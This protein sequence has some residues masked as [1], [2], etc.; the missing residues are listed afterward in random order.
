MTRYVDIFGMMYYI[1]IPLT[2]RDK[3]NIITKEQNH[4]IPDVKWELIQRILLTEQKFGHNITPLDLLRNFEVQEI[5]HII[6]NIHGILDEVR[7]NW[8]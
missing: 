8:I 1:T 4:T 5:I 3:H 2:D 6:D 7:R